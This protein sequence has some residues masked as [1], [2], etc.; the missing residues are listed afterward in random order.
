MNIRLLS[1][2]LLLVGSSLTSTSLAQTGPTR[3]GPTRPGPT[4]PSG[5]SALNS[6]L[7]PGVRPPLP[8]I[9]NSPTPTAPRLL[10]SLPTLTL[11]PPIPEL[12]KVEYAGNGFIEVAHAI[13]LVPRVQAKSPLLLELAQRAVQASFQA[14]TTLSEVDVSVFQREGFQGLA[15]P[16]PLLTASVPLGRLER[17]QK[18]DPQT[19]KSWWTYGR[20]WINVT[21]NRAPERMPSLALEQ[22]LT[23]YG[24]PPDLSKQRIHQVLA[25]LRGRGMNSSVLFHGDPN[26][27]E[28]ALTFDDAPHPLFAPLLLDTLRRG[29]VKAT[30]FC[31]GRNAEAYPY[32]VRDMARAGHEIGNHTYDHVRLPLLTSDE[33]R[34]ELL[35]ANAVLEPLSRQ[36]IRYFR[37]PGGEYSLDTLKTTREAGMVTAFWTDD[38]GDFANPGVAVLRTRLLEKLRPGGI[39]LL[40]DNALETNI[41][42][43]AFL[44]E[45]RRS[46]IRLVPINALDTPMQR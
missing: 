11:T 32:F 44:N 5:S 1:A 31:I 6:S 40:H 42:L 27:G 4:G 15:G 19:P 3:P 35:K 39:V 38:P 21:T 33:A 8:P 41:V 37:P 26:S 13:L 30:F 46:G 36:K 12:L 10:Q 45:A 2:L 34:D 23:F 18:L 22:N 28:S 9:Q 7:T 24:S 16:L 25:S 17:F 29:G 14:R 43:P 20:L